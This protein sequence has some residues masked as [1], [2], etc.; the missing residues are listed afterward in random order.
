MCECCFSTP[1]PKPG[2]RWAT[3]LV[4]IQPQIGRWQHNL[5]D[6]EENPVVTTGSSGTPLTNYAWKVPTCLLLPN[7]VA[8]RAQTTPLTN[9]TDHARRLS[10]A[11]I[12]HRSPFVTVQIVRC[13]VGLDTPQV[14]R[15]VWGVC[16]ASL[17]AICLCCFDAHRWVWIVHVVLFALPIDVHR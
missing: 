1:P 17:R 14:A 8:K 7:N 15:C 5:L 11:V 16:R 2:S 10:N 6:R 9:R 3:H 12:Y 13:A 4:S